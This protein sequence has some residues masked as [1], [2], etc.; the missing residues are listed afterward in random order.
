MQYRNKGR[1]L[2]AILLIVLSVTVLIGTAVAAFMPAIGTLGA[3]RAATP[4]PTLVPPTPTAIPPT[5]TPIP[6][7][8][9]PP[10]K[11]AAQAIY[12]MDQQ[13]GSVLENDN[14]FTPLPMAS[15]TK[16]M[17]ALIAIQTADLDQTIT[18]PQAAVNRVVL[19]GG[20]SANLI[21]GDKISLKNLL[22]ALLLPSGDDAAIAIADGLAGTPDAFVARMNLFAYHLRLFQTHYANPDGLSLTAEED[23]QHYTSAADLE[24]LARYAMNIPLF[25]EIVRTSTYILP[26][27]GQHHAYHWDNTNVLL[28]SYNGMLG[29]KT[30]HTYAAGY[31]LVFAAQQHGHTLI[32]VLL[33]S[34]TEQERN[35]DVVKLL[36]WGFSQI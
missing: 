28:K 12:L 11:I 8:T 7:P 34:P 13:S 20:S 24:R 10:P 6:T 25:A 32:G 29:I 23:Q 4:T 9:T 15:T 18:I 27:N 33:D 16:I 19:D 22:Y 30:G 5:P 21:A 36:N 3:Q 2:L 17:T 31:C 35:Q 26:A 1:T 14:G